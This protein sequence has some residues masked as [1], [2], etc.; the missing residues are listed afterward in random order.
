[1]HAL[2]AGMHAP[3]TMQGRAVDGFQKDFVLKLLASGH[4]TVAQ[5]NEGLAAALQQVT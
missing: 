2:I 5:C 1:M 4:S 3:Y